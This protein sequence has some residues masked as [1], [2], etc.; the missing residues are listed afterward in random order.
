MSCI[1]Q[2]LEPKDRPTPRPQEQGAA[3]VVA[4]LVMV[5]CALLGASAITTST[6][7]LQISR[8]ERLHHQALAS[9]DAGARWLL[10]QTENLFNDRNE[11]LLPEQWAQRQER[12]E[13]PFESDLP[14]G[15]PVTFTFDPIPIPV[16]CQPGV[17]GYRLFM[18]RTMQQ[19]EGGLPFYTA[20]I[21]GRGE[22]DRRTSEV[23]I[24]VEIRLPPA[25]PVSGQDH[26]G[27]KM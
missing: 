9:A 12:R 24:E 22:R 15:S 4:L 3:L 26:Y 7:D 19:Q 13:M 6:T 25:G 8:Q 10:S 1:A 20:R 2:R 16:E 14:Q 11:C 5:I 17:Q 23:V 18:S 27:D 21:R